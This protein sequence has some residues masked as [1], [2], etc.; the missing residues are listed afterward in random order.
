M[1]DDGKLIKNINKVKSLKNSINKRKHKIIDM[2]LIED[3][4]DKIDLYNKIKSDL[5]SLS[6]K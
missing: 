1:F 3:N 5:E 2:S 4:S 6:K